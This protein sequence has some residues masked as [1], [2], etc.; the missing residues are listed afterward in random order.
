MVTWR[1]LRQPACHF[2]AGFPVPRGTGNNTETQEFRYLSERH[3][4]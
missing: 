3:E 1:T 2:L 4:L